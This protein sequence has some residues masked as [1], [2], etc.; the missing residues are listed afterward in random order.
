MS[1]FTFFDSALAISTSCCCPT[2]RFLMGVEGF[3][4]SP[5]RLSRSMVSLRDVSQSIRPCLTTSLPMKIFSVID[6]SGIV[7]SS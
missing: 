4:A 5:T 7:V 2:P 3:T 1:S 6:S